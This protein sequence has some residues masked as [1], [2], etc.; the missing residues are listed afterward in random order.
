M[1]GYLDSRKLTNVKGRLNY[2]TDKDKQEN[3]VDYFNTADEDFWLL[4]AKEN[5]IRHKETKAGGKCC[6]ARELIIGIPQNSPIIAEELC[7]I[8]KTKFGV[9]CAC[10][11]H[12]NNKNNVINRHCHLIFS[13]RQK[14]EVPEITKE[15]RASRTYY[16]DDTGHKCKK[17]NAV[18]T[19]KKGTIL[20]KGTTRYFSDKDPLFKSQNFIYKCKELILKDTLN[21]DWSYWAEKQN[22]AL[23]EK[24]IGKNNPNAKYI[25]RNN[26]LKAKIKSIC[27][28]G[29]FIMNKNTGTSFKVF[30]EEFQITSF[31]APNYEEN[32]NNLNLFNKELQSLC[33]NQ[34]E[35]EV[36]EH[37]KINNDLDT[38]KM[39]YNRSGIMQEIQEDIVDKYKEE[40]H[41]NHKPTVIEFVKNKLSNMFYRIKKLVKLQDFLEIEKKNQ[42]EVEKDD[43]TNKL[44]IKDEHYLKEQHYLEKD[45]FYIEL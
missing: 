30:T 28:A 34:I 35:I 14:L 26:K 11:I 7:N 1:S 23:S 18:K 17:E 22:K 42:L 24:H 44:Y 31:S 4:L 32:Y 19:V 36:K 9:E 43:R 25:D 15:K 2:I 40:S 13:E 16:Y 41:T 33:K 3:I 20:Q 37:N 6:E 5:R 21:I 10:A 39:N 27:N 29:D 38:L 45:D 8:F 12:Q